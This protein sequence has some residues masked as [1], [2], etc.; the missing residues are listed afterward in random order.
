MHTNNGEEVQE[1]TYSDIYASLPQT[2]SGIPLMVT[3]HST[4]HGLSTKR[5]KK[6]SLRKVDKA[7]PSDQSKS[8]T[9]WIPQHPSFVLDHYWRRKKQRVRGRTQYEDQE[10]P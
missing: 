6:E 9:Q 1:K 8:S 7:S 2:A 3:D 5:S 10:T 4:G